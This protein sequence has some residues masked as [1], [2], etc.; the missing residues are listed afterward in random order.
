VVNPYKP[1]GTHR[2]SLALHRQIDRL[3]GDRV[4]N[5]PPGLVGDED[6]ARLCG[7]LES[8]GGVHHVAEQRLII[9]ADNHLAGTDPDSRFQ[10]HVPL[11]TEHLVQIDQSCLHLAGCAHGP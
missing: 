11:R 2:C 9:S 3:A 5:Q 4:G 6:P 8:R 7:R 1:P 10:R